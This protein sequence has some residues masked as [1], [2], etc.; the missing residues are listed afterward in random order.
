[1]RSRTMGWA[2]RPH[3]AWSSSIRQS[4]ARAA[5]RRFSRMYSAAPSMSVSSSSMRSWGSKIRASTLPRR[6]LRRL[7]QLAEPSL[8]PLDHLVELVDLTLDGIGLHGSVGDVRHS[9]RK[10]VDTA[11]PDPF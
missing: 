10:D 7:L 6:P 3:I 4:R 11:R 8:G 9:P 5:E 2:V 1:M